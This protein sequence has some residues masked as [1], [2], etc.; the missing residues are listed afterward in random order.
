M[1]YIF[2]C[3][4]TGIGVKADI[5]HAGLSPDRRKTNH[6]KFVRDEIQV[7]QRLQLSRFEECEFSKIS[8]SPAWV[9]FSPTQVVLDIKNKW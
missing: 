1:Q 3:D 7:M 2:L 6:H 9:W 5:Y 4:G 8:R